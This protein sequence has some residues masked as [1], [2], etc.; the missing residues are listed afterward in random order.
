MP[1]FRLW[2]I[3]L[4]V[5]EFGVGFFADRLGLRTMSWSRRGFELAPIE[6]TS[7]MMIFGPRDSM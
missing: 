5:A 6:E 3:S 2:Y 4:H 7:E 1:T